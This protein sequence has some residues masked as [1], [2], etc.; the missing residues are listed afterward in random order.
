MSY[1]SYTLKNA[2]MTHNLFGDDVTKT[3]TV[4]EEFGPEQAKAEADA[5]ISRLITELCT[6]AKEAGFSLTIN[7][8]PL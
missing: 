2:S 7:V 1:N 4:S 8:T 3:A 5:R 6:A